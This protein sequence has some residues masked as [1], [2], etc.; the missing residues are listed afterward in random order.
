MWAVLDSFGMDFTLT[1]NPCSFVK[2]D[3][4]IFPTVIGLVDVLLFSLGATDKSDMGVSLLSATPES[5]LLSPI[6]FVGVTNFE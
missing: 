5:L 2:L 6:L 1:L 3:P 4:P